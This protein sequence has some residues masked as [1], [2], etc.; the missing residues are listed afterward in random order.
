[1]RALDSRGPGAIGG[2]DGEGVAAPCR[3]RAFLSRLTARG[4]TSFWL[5]CHG[6]V[7]GPSFLNG[8]RLMFHGRNGVYVATQATIV[9][10]LWVIN[11]LLGPT[12][13]PGS[14]RS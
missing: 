13:P 10:R 2:G 6:G 1:M 3:R 8:L 7:V 14:P 5:V 12:G 4:S 9:R 11:S